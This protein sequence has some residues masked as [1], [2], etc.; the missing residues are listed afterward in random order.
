MTM[1][2][3][4][5]LGVRPLQAE[6]FRISGQGGSAVRRLDRWTVSL[7]VL[8]QLAAR[9]LVR[10]TNRAPAVSTA[11]ISGDYDAVVLPGSVAVF[12][13]ERYKWIAAVVDYAGAASGQDNQLQA[14]G[15][16]SIVAYQPA[17]PG[18]AY[19]ITPGGLFV[20]LLVDAAGRLV[21]ANPASVGT[22]AGQSVT[23]A[24]G[25]LAPAIAAVAALTNY[26]TG[27]EVTGGGATGA[28]ALDVTVTGLLEGTLHYA[29]EVPVG[30]GLAIA[31]LIVEFVRPR[32]AS[33]V[34]TAITLNVPSFGIGNA[35]ESAA[36]HGY[37]L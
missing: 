33:A 25:A 11:A 1:L 17:A 23:G 5:E 28:A 9:I 34:N 3:E 7:V 36:I 14:I 35:I 12:A 16:E 29:I 21:T 27:I 37:R 13:V 19:G 31:P 30:A 22:D 24:A 8:N 4:R 6:L 26:L 10:F 15:L 18:P 2:P 32:P 20:P